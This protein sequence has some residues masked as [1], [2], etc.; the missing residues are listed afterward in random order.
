MFPVPALHD[1][2]SPSQQLSTFSKKPPSAATISG[3]LFPHRKCIC[4]LQNRELYATRVEIRP[5]GLLPL[6]PFR[7]EDH[8]PTSCMY[9]PTVILVFLFIETCQA[10]FAY[11]PASNASTD[12]LL[13]AVI[14]YRRVCTFSNS[15]SRIQ[16][17][18]R[19]NPDENASNK[20]WPLMRNVCNAWGYASFN[21]G[22]SAIAAG[23]FHT[24]LLFT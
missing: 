9:Y 11:L 23:E 24:A 4:T 18:P 16:H 15:L 12:R 1:Y 5:Q 13:Y 3:H 14:S 10:V 2:S 21:V 19:L 8:R 7:P 20:P 17:H 6:H 22:A